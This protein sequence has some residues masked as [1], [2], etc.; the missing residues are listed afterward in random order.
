MSDI[1]LIL[2]R[3]QLEATERLIN[4][5]IS[6]IPLII[7][8][9]YDKLPDILKGMKTENLHRWLAEYCVEKGIF[10][11]KQ[12]ATKEN[13]LGALDKHA[14]E[15]DIDKALSKVPERYRDLV[16]GVLDIVAE[17]LL[18]LMRGLK[19]KIVSEDQ[20]LDFLIK[21]VEYAMAQQG[22]VI[23]KRV[24]EAYRRLIEMRQK[25]PNLTRRLFG[26]LLDFAL[27]KGSN[28]P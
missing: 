12:C 6:K 10:D 7:N 4:S 22:P 15:L 24:A 17:L 13:I 19:A 18:N 25:Y 14:D 21:L 9:F 23:D 11:A 8:I 16:Y 20:F 2:E 27:E 3:I 1:D 26:W 28:F 5:L